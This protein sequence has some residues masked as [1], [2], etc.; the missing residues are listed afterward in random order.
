[1]NLSHALAVLLYEVS[2]KSDPVMN[3]IDPAP[4]VLATGLEIEHMFAHMKKSL[5][6]I[7]FLD[8][9]NPEH[10][11]RAFRRI[12]G[13]AGLTARDVRIIRGLMS[14]IDWTENKRRENNNVHNE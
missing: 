10:L 12:F 13:S 4:K 2:I 7:D 14:R 11:L 3:S 1:M 6:N 9:Q 5:L 8:R